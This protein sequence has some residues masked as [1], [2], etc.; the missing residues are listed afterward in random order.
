MT[1]Q[2]YSISPL[3][4]IQNAAHIA[5][6]LGT[7]VIVI[8]TYGVIRPNVT[9]SLLSFPPATTPKDQ[10]LVET[11]IRMFASTRVVVGLCG[12][13]AWWYGAYKVLGVQMVCGVTMAAVDG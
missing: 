13:S 4:N 6:G 3:L 7:F 8:N 12:I 9:L 10:K 5:A 1:T 11:V 2:L